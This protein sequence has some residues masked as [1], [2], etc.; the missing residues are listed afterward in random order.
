MLKN[1]ST[2]QFEPDD[3]GIILQNIE[4]HS[5]NNK[6]TNLKRLGTSDL[7]PKLLLMQG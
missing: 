7:S 5:P 1:Y 3:E 6:V 4:S 2:T